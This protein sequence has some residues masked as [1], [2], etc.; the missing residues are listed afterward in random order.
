MISPKEQ[1]HVNLRAV[2]RV[3]YVIE[4]NLVDHR[5][6]V[7]PE[8]PGKETSAAIRWARLFREFTQTAVR[9]QQQAGF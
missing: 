9:Q 7:V 8:W 4:E 5:F 6:V 2:T 3:P 1:R